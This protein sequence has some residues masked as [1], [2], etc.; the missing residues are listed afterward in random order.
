MAVR[1][2]A[3]KWAVVAAAKEMLNKTIEYNRSVRLPKVL[4]QA[5][6]FFV[7]MTNNNYTKIFLPDT[8]QT[9]IVERKD[10]NRFMANE[11]SQA[12]AEQLYISLR[13]ALARH[14]SSEKGLP[15]II[16]DGFVN[17]DFERTKQVLSL[18]D[19]FSQNHQ[20][21]FFTCQ[22]HLMPLFKKEQILNLKETEHALKQ[23]SIGQRLL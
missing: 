10:G 13:L 9:L 21:I 1:Q 22:E 15:I 11:L 7:F 2:L 17:F 12:T 6:S 20:V 5:E 19:E 4:N 23:V 8:E 18:L 3:H 14:L 16:D